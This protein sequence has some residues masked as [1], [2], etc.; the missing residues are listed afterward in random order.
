MNGSKVVVPPLTLLIVLEGLFVPHQLFV[1]VTELAMLLR[2]L[3]TA[4]IFP[5]RRLKPI[6]RVP[7]VF[8]T[9][10]PPPP[11]PAVAVLAVFPVTVILE[12]VP[13]SGLVGLKKIPPPSVPAVL[14]LITVPVSIRRFD[15]S[16]MPPPSP[17]D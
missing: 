7:L 6:V 8:P 9:S 17:D 16:S 2:L 10:M 1:A 3:P 14:P 4:A 12:N 13:L 5:S 11:C 15:T